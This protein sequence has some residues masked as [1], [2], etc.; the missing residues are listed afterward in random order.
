[1][2]SAFISFY[3]SGV[4]FY[5][6]SVFFKPILTEFGWS[7][8]VTA[9]AVSA[10]RLE[11]GLEGPIIG[12]LI[13]KFGPRK[14]MIFS[15]VFVGI[16]FVLL[17][18]LNSLVMFYI[19][20]IFVLAVGYNSGFGR[21]TMV[22]VA[23][24]FIRKRSRA[25]AIY[26]LGA[27]I[28]GAVIVPILGW[29]IGNYGWR[30]TAL[31]AGIGV[32]LLMIPAALV[33]R[34]K[35]EQYGY[36]PDGEPPEEEEK[37][38]NTEAKTA[39]GGGAISTDEIETS[40]AHFGEINFTVWE[41]MATPA[42]W[43]LALG[44]AARGGAMTAIILHEVAYLT[45]IGIAP[46][47]AATAL[48]L[49]VL[50][51]IPGRLTFG[52]FGDRLNKKY[53]YMASFLISSLG[54]FILAHIRNMEMLYLFLVVY[55]FGYGGGIPL[56]YAIKAEYFGRKAFA[57]ISGFTMFFLMGPTMAGPIFAGWVYDV[58]GSYYTAFMTFGV[59]YLLGAIPIF[60]LKR[61]MQR[62][63]PT[64]SRAL[65]FFLRVRDKF[66]R[67]SKEGKSG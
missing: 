45:D 18:R 2:A 52:W 26:S 54:V 34:H 8:A 39:R 17:S 21:A 53:V 63:T 50:L 31:M 61:P 64:T 40:R 1:M 35:P 67:K 33:L 37:K 7:R 12:W 43:L 66:S 58:T 10:S 48:G 30:T 46:Q 55:G 6:F 36:F 57:T 5:G 44:S 32:W 14:L 49:M 38:G 16:G 27:G 56:L 42:F 41:A 23:N 60:F 51:S 22:A 47:A 62:P 13:D 65:F 19:L 20:F 4:W 9:G 25:F 59:L 28:G 3:G 15:A 29:L 24:W 11:G